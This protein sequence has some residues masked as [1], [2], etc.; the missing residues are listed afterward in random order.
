VIVWVQ[1]YAITFISINVC[2]G[3]ETKAPKYEYLT[4]M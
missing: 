1:M 4:Y 3:R 2:L